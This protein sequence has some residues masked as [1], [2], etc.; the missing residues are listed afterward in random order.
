M[1]RLGWQ[2]IL[3][4]FGCLDDGCCPM[5]NLLQF[6]SSLLKDGAKEAWFFTLAISFALSTSEAMSNGFST[7]DGDRGLASLTGVQKNVL[8]P[9]CIRRGTRLP[10][11]AKSVF[12]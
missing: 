4:A 7:S 5:T 6:A 1:V 12:S 11:V 8:T 9:F 2:A 10:G 3:T